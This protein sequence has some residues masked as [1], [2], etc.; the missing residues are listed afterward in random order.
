MRRNGYVLKNVAMC[1]LLKKDFQEV[2]E[3]SYVDYMKLLMACFVIGI[4]TWLSSACQNEVATKI[5]N[6]LFSI[7]VPYFFICS[8]FF[9]F[10]NDERVDTNHRMIQYAKSIISMYVIWT[11]IYLPFTI[12]SYYADGLNFRQGTLAFLRGF[13]FIGEHSYSWPLWY[14]LALIIAVVLIYGMRQLHFKPL[15]IAI[16]GSVMFFLGH[17]INYLHTNGLD[18]MGTKRVIDLYFKIFQNTRNGLFLGLFYVSLGL[19]IA[20]FGRIKNLIVNISII[21]IGGCLAYQRFLV[22]MPLLIFALF[23]LT[24]S[25][26]KFSKGAV[27]CRKISTIFYFTHMSLIAPVYINKLQLT[28]WLLYIIVIFILF[29]FSFFVLKYKETRWYKYIFR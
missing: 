22:G 1:F 6:L 11:F 23:S 12:Y 21:T 15:S 7:A 19:V 10:R 2:K 14:L 4:H 20:H 17:Y 29:L 16:V 28:P 5:L 25:E 3:F 18:F 27:T 8:G 26:S 13:L 24:L 9:L